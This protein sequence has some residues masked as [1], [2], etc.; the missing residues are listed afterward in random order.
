[1]ALK[2][3][4]M[5]TVAVVAIVVLLIAVVVASLFLAIKGL[6]VLMILFGFFMMFSF[7]GNEEIQGDFGITGIIIGVILTIIGLVLLF[8]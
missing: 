2:M 5:I 7:P 1:M 4:I 3:D 8:V 6:A